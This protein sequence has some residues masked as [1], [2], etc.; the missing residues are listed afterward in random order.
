MASPATP[1]SL[2]RTLLART[3]TRAGTSLLRRTAFPISVGLTTA[4]GLVLAANHQRPM[5]FDSVS[6]PLP[7]TRTLASGHKPRRKELLDGE[8][9]KQ[10]SGGSLAGM[11]FSPSALFSDGWLFGDGD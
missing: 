8:T 10:L 3:R 11:V 1:A 4:G 9:V 7:Q 2:A 5:Q 6:V